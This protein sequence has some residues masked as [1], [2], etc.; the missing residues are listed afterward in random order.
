MLIPK[1]IKM[2]ILTYLLDDK[3]Q[4]QIYNIPVTRSNVSQGPRRRTKG[5]NE[6]IRTLSP[7]LCFN[8]EQRAL[9]K[10]A[11]PDILFVGL[12]QTLAKMWMS[13][14]DRTKYIEM[15]RADHIRFCREVN[16][17]INSGYYNSPLSLFLNDL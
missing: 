7:Y 5:P 8:K 13:L 16:E 3:I 1:E 17:L 14:T 9:V 11:N 15:S 12:T 10:A 6:P 4:K 2:N